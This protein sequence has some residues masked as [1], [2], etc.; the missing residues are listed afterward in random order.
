LASCRQS[1]HFED[2]IMTIT[3]KIIGNHYRVPLDWSQQVIIEKQPIGCWKVVG[4]VSGKHAY[5]FMDLRFN[6]DGS[7]WYGRI[8]G[9]PWDQGD[10]YALDVDSI[11]DDAEPQ[12]LTAKEI[13]ISINGIEIKG[14]DDRGVEP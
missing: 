1:T 5:F 13:K 12:K 6:A 8:N 14:Y 11:T 10:R 9:E 4:T 2:L 7:P 3:A